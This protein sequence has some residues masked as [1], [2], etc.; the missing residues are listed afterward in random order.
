M[1]SAWMD[2]FS[3]MYL[4]REES[5]RYRMRPITIGRYLVCE[6]PDEHE[7]FGPLR[8]LRAAF[9]LIIGFGLGVITQF[10]GSIL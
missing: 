6:D 9:W 2:V 5:R 10:I 1:V 8:V 7:K 4:V 3:V